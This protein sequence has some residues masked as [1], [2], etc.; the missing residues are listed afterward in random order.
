MEFLRV[1]KQEQAALAPYFRAQELHIG[2]FSC[3]FQFMWDDALKPAYAIVENCLVLRELF[4]GKYYY[5]Y[6]LSRTGDREEEM[7]AI[8]ALE[9]IAR[10]T[11]RRLHFTNVPKSRVGDLIL[12]YD[13]ALVTNNRR[14]RDYLYR[15]EDF[16]EYP[17]KKYAGQRNHVKKFAR[18]YPDWEFFEASPSDM[19]RVESFL[20]RY[21]AVQRSKENFLAEEEMNEVYA[22][23]G[24]M[25]ELGV[26]AGILTVGGEVVGFSAG[27]KC[28]DMVV[29]HVEKALRQYEGV[30][31]FLAQQFARTFCTDGVSYLNRMDDAGDLGLR[32]S[33]LQYG[34]C[35][36]VDKFNV[37]PKRAIDAVGRLPTVQTERLTLM[38]VRDEDA[39]A[40]AMLASDVERNRF[41]GYDWRT[42]HRRK[43]AAKTFLRDARED[44]RSGAR[45]RSGS[46][47]GRRS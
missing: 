33:K 36:I 7:R 5:H 6:P 10:D 46:T 14:W 16:R 42:D 4:A 19:G 27:E 34:P 40:Y 41:W 28:G 31:P 45:C 17:G 2:D 3:A 1:S 11:D 35:E 24:H 26:F 21:E 47:A 39:E 22:L 23:L 29:V 9:T 37:I 15:V 13:E 44:L 30:Y 20:H 18:L 12:R 38:P 43:P 25:R 8:K 32:K